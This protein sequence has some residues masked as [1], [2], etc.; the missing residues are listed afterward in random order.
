VKA[1]NTRRTVLVNDMRGEPDFVRGPID[2]LSELA[3]PVIIDGETVAVLN[4]ESLD[5]NAF[6]R[7]DQTL[8][9]TLAQHVASAY[10]RISESKRQLDN[11]SRLSRTIRHDL[12]SP[13]QV[14][15]NS[16]YLMRHSPGSVEE[17]AETIDDSVDYVV[18]ILEDLRTLT[19]HRELVKSQV[20]LAELVEHSLG[21]VVIPQSVKVERAFTGPVNIN[22]DS[23]SIRR[24]I[25][26]LVKNTVEAM[27]EG[28]TLTLSVNVDE[29]SVELVV[30]DTGN[31]ISD[32]VMRSLFKP[33]YSTKS[34][35]R[36]LGLALC[37]SVVEAH[38]GRITVES[39]L[40]EGTAFKVM[41][42]S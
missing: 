28:G 15:K 13:L 42:P 10:Q 34:S 21:S 9:E 18:R 38:G 27:P 29:K 1:A 23:T 25:G 35:G 30:K 7:E 11:I 8:L 32:E 17:M 26:N 40:G 2:S 16:A 31:G 20:D 14:I 19:T 5:L 12:M 33:F 22:V 6:T 36:G 39:R 41:L 3:T 24:C 37:K 4:V